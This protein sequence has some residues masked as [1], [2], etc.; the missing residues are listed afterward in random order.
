MITP[1]QNLELAQLDLIRRLR[2]LSLSQAGRY[3]Y[4]LREKRKQ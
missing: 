1:E 4:L 2:G 3:D